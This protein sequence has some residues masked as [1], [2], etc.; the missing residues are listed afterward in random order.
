MIQFSDIFSDGFGGSSGPLWG[1]F[2][3]KGATCLE[4]QL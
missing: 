4:D 2:I 1:A 3:S